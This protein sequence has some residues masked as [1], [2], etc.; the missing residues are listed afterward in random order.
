MIFSVLPWIVAITACYALV[1]VFLRYPQ[2]RNSRV[3][4]RSGEAAFIGAAAEVGGGSIDS[5]FVTACSCERG[6][7]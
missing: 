3:N 7:C 4:I 2:P 1:R 6:V 5:D